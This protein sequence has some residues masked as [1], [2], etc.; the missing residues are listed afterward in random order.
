ML[1][2]YYLGQLYL[3]E[4]GLP[5]GQLTVQDSNHSH[6]ADSIVLVQHYTLAVSDTLH[7]HTVDGV[8]LTEHKT[9]AVNDTAHQHT[10][11]GL[12]LTQQYI[13]AVS[14]SSH[15]HNTDGVAVLQNQLLVVNDSLHGHTSENIEIIQYTLLN[16]PG[17]TVHGITSD[18]ITLIENKLLG[19]DDSL[20]SLT[21]E[22][23]SI[24]D[25]NSL[26][27]QF[28]G[29]KPEQGDLGSFTDSELP[30]A[31]NLPKNYDKFGQLIE[32]DIEEGTV[33]P[34]DIS[35]GEFTS[36]RFVNILEFDD[37]FWWIDEHDTH[38]IVEEYD[39]DDENNLYEK[40][41][42]EYGSLQ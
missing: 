16:P 4:S 40:G 33:N 34:N 28:G 12:T 42:I 19:I 10:V 14:D 9:L 21:S 1:G 23:I 2:G 3:G 30:A 11:D 5:N 13:L 27:V 18:V 41:Q 22:Q 17:D 7:G 24:I 38:V 31:L 36:N 39:Y 29:Y 26:G 6:T 15:S 20:H 8:S 32:S 35:R 25:W 37:G